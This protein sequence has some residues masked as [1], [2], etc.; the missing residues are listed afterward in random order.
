MTSR[1]RV[2]IADD[3]ALVREGTRE[4]LAREPDLAVVG[5]ARDGEE[6]VALAAELLPDVVIVD[7]GMPHLNGIEATRRIKAGHP[8]IGVL[9]LTMHDDDG[10]LFA[11]LEAGAAGYLLKD[12]HG[13]EVVAAVRSIRAGEAVLHP[14]VTAKVLA[15]LRRGES[16][17]RPE[18]SALSARERQVLR[19]AAAGMGNQ[20]IAAELVL[21]PRTVQAHLSNVF[22]KLQVASRTEAI[23]HGLRRG[24]FCLE[25][26]P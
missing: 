7:I 14:A 10:Y 21:S 19:L 20:Q 5:E 22:A 13:A 16:A 12:C 25:D 6:A 18:E 23:V 4:I 8:E 11:I 3:H 26:L 1:T 9:V 17:R 15:R 2:L 24:W